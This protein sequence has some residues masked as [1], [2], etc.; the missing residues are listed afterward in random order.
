MKNAWVILP[1][2]LSTVWVGCS[3][4][5][6]QPVP[7]GAFAYASY[8]TAGVALVTG[9]FTMDV[10]DSSTITGE[11]HLRPIGDPEGIGP[12]TGDGVLLGGFSEGEV[13][14]ELNPQYRDN[15]LQL[16]GILQGDRYA[17]EWIW[18]SFVGVTNHGTFEALRR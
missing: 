5:P 9:W 6:T 10:S 16:R 17:G 7:R 18:V 14:V 1:L 3:G 8:D 11:W 15:N 2:I 13:W 4:T 12:Q